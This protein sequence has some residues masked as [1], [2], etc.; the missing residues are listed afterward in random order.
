[1]DFDIVSCGDDA[2]KV[3]TG[4]ND[5]RQGLMRHLLKTGK[6]QEV[7]IGRDSI[8]VQFDPVRMRPKEALNML[9]DAT[10]MH[11]DVEVPKSAHVTLTI[12][13]DA[14]SAPDLS[15]CA[16]RDGLGIPEFLQRIQTS[17]LQ[18]DMLG[19]SPGFAYVRGVD[20]SLDGMRL[21]IPRQRVRAG[22]IGFITGFLGIYALD[23]PGGWPIIGHTDAPLFDKTAEN[24]FLLMAGTNLQVQW[25]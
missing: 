15:A 1:M 12:A 17:N 16:E 11:T 9:H 14:R 7:V 10:S 21:D 13:T 23:G 19:F 25:V 24:P 22:S 2:L 18:V 20:S 8:T 6:W 5:M 3:I 4:P